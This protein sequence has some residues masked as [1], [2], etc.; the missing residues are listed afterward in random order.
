MSKLFFSILAFS[1]LCASAAR[2]PVKEISMTRKGT[3][4]FTFDKKHYHKDNWH[5]LF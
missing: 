4:K 1:I 5:N 2:K 3:S